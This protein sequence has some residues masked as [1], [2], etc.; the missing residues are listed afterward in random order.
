MLYYNDSEYTR[1]L[2]IPFL[3][4]MYATI[5]FLI[6]IKQIIIKKSRIII[7]IKLGI[8][9]WTQFKGSC[10]WEGTISYCTAVSVEEY[11]EGPNITTDTATCCWQC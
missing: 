7:I 6:I 4:F 2:K 5:T 3:M 11:K 9:N 8:L 10:T 1:K